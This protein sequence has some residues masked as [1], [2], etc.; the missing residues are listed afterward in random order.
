MITI[1]ILKLSIISRQTVYVL[2][3]SDFQHQTQ[4]LF[5]NGNLNNRNMSVLVGELGHDYS[6]LFRTTDRNM[7]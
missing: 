6:H 3:I 7:Q 4:N 1:K 2:M 5:C